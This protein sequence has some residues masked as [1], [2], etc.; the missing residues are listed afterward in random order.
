MLELGTGAAWEHLALSA[1]LE[2][3]GGSTTLV[4]KAAAVAH[5]PVLAWH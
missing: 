5:G 1:W 4:D 2:G 3:P